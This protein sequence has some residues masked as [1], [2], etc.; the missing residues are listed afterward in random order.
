M[1]ALWHWLYVCFPAV[2]P[3]HCRASTAHADLAVRA[4]RSG[5]ATPTPPPSVLP[6]PSCCSY[7]MTV[8]ADGYVQSP[9]GL[10][11][12]DFV[13]GSGESPV[14]GQVCFGWAGCCGE[15]LH[16]CF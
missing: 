8:V 7:D 15:P 6:Y 9:D 5:A 2:A 14:D 4:C 13:E 1:C 16:S 11:Y 3:Q 10:I 12:R